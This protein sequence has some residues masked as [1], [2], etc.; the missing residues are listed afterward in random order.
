LQI[1][2]FWFQPWYFCKWV[3]WQVQ[4]FVK[5]TVKKQPYSLEDQEYLTRNI[6]NISKLSWDE[7]PPKDRKKIM[8]RELWL[9]DNQQQWRERERRGALANKGMDGDIDIPGE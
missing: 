1:A 9:Q 7:K 6:L 2:R 8:A 3:F 4:W 5:Y